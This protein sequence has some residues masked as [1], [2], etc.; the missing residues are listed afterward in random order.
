MQRRT[1]FVLGS[2]SLGLDDWKVRRYPTSRIKGFL[3]NF[4]QVLFAQTFN[5]LYQQNVTDINTMFKVFRRECIDG[6]HFTGDGFNFDMELVCKIVRNGFEPLEV[7]VNY[8]AAA[9]RRERRSISCSVRIR[10]TTSCSGAALDASDVY[11]EDHHWGDQPVDIAARDLPA[12]K[13]R[14]LIDAL[15]ASGRVVEI[16]CGHGRIL[17]TDRASPPGSRAPRLRHPPARDTHPSTSRFTLG[18][19]TRSRRSLTKTRLARRGVMSDILEH[20]DRSGRDAARRARRCSDPAARSCRSRPSR[21]SHSRSIAFYRR[22]F[23]D[24]LYVE[25]KEHVQSLQRPEPA[26]ARRAGLRDHRQFVRLSLPGSSDGRDPV[27]PREDSGA[28]QEILGKNPYYEESTSTWG[29]VHVN[30]RPRAARRERRRVRGVATIPQRRLERRRPAL[31]GGYALRGSKGCVR[32]TLLQRLAIPRS[33]HRG[34]R[35]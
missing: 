11:A 35:Q 22:L 21:R 12:L 8:V 17:N 20:L 7:P 2:R 18:D 34:R 13:T 4:A 5:V 14:Y 15:P 3:M 9:S 24:D 28:A 1:S 10:R 25:T 29:K 19:P 31:H 32:R 26:N 33:H 23:G 27:C 16:G 30:L 6:C